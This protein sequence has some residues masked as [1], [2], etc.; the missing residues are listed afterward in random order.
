[1]LSIADSL[2][3]KSGVTYI[4]FSIVRVAW[5]R[6]ALL[7]KGFGV[8]CCGWGRLFDV[9]NEFYFDFWVADQPVQGVF[10]FCWLLYR[11][12]EIVFYRDIG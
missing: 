2:Q 11:T 1:M 6:N 9:Y 8:V 4:I 5:C 7:K 3:A 10:R 12:S